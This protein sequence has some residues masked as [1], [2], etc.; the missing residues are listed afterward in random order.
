M[1]KKFKDYYN[2]ACARLIGEKLLAVYPSFAYDAFVAYIK[3]HV[4]GKTFHDRQDVFAD[5]FEQF[6][7]SSYEKNI[8]LLHKI[9]GK[10]LQQDT[11]MFI[12]GWWLWPV[13]RYVQRHGAQYPEAS[14]EFIYELTKRFTGEFAIRSLI[15]AFPKETLKTLLKW[16]LDPNVHVRRLSSEAIR[17]RLPWGQKLPIVLQHKQAV[18]K[19]LTNLKDSPEKFVQKSVGNNLNDLFK[20]D[21]VFAV[22]IINT[23]KQART[24]SPG[25][26]WI[27][28]HGSRN[29]I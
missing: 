29:Q 18:K 7:T 3:K 16:S 9:L 27:I 22:D 4:A 6:L 11:G 8:A 23:W 2:V 12:H 14:L 15:A 19:I 1:A 5:A 26:Q 24:L 20:D 28:K 25:A 10:E 21:P 13:G 17:T